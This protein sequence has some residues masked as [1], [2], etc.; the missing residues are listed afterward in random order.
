MTAQHSPAHVVRRPRS[1]SEWFRTHCRPLPLVLGAAVLGGPM[2]PHVALAA[3][4]RFVGKDANP[5]PTE[6]DKEAVDQPP[7]KLNY[8]IPKTWE[9]ILK[10]V[11]EQTNST[12][13]ADKVP[14]GT[15]SRRDR[16]EYTREEAVRIINQEIEKLGFRVVEKGEYLVVIDL[17]SQRPRYDRPT[18]P[19]PGVWQ[20][21]APYV[22]IS[23]G[24]PPVRQ[25][26]SVRPQPQ[27][28]PQNQQQV[29]NSSQ[30]APG[31]AGSSQRPARTPSM[32]QQT[33]LE[34]ADYGEPQP[35]P[36]GRSTAQDLLLDQQAAPGANAPTTVVVFRARN[37]RA[38]SLAKHV[39]K[40]FR[41]R[42]ELLQAGRNGLPAF[43]VRSEVARSAESPV[44]FAVAI[45]EEKEELLIDAPA[46]DADAM[47]KLLRKL[48][49]PTLEAEPIQ[50]V[51]TTRTVCEVAMQFESQ[52]EKIQAARRGRPARV[53]D[54]FAQ[55]DFSESAFAQADAP[56]DP[57]AP[58]T[59]MPN[60]AGGET[61]VVPRGA[62]GDVVGNLKG[63]VVIESVPDL[64]T[65]ILKGNREDV[66][67]V[68]QVIRELEKLSEQTA[69][70]LELL[71]LQN[72]NSDALAEL[73]T[74][75]YESLTKFP[76]R[77]TQ[78]RQSVA[79]LSVSKPNAILIIAPA[80]DMP[81]IK[82]LASELDRPVDPET[83]FQVFHLETAIATQVE[84]ML[85]QFFTERPGLG[86]RV[87]VR[88]DP[89]SN[90]IIVSARPNDLDE[91][92]T[93]IRKLDQHD[94]MS[95]SQL[96][97]VPLQ[98]AVATELSAV[99]NLAI[100]S[101]ISP[102]SSQGATSIFGAGAGVG[103]AQVSEE[104]R[105]VRSSVLQFLAV[106]EAGQKVLRSGVLADI[107]ITPDPRMNSL[108]ISAP[109]ASMNLLVELIKQLDRPTNQVAEIKV[110]TL[111]NADAQL[112][113]QQ[114]QALFSTSAAGQGGQQQRQLGVQVAGAEDASSGLI[115]LR[116][117]V[118]TRTNS[119]IAI[120]GGDALRVVEA[121]MLRLDE[122]DVRERRNTIYRLKNS[123]SDSIAAAITSFFTSQSDLASADPN[124]FSSIEQLERNVIVVSEPVSN[125]LMISAT[126]RYN[127][128]ILRLI[129]KLD[130]APQQVIIQALLVEV[131]LNDT[132]EFGIELG[133][134]D[135]ILFDRSIIDN[136][137][138]TTTTT[139][140]NNTTVTQ[141]NVI[142][143]SSSP[144]YLFGNPATPL[145]NNT[146]PSVPTGRVGTQGLSN[147]SVG[148]TNGDLGFG[149]LV[150]SASSESVSLLLRALSENRQV[151]VLSRPQIRTLDNQ[152]AQ[153]VQGQNVPI[154]T[155]VTISSNGGVP[156]PQVT[157]D[158]AGV[159]LNVTPRIS[160]DGNV[161]MALVAE[162]S[163][164]NLQSGVAIFTDAAT[165]NTVTSPVK[166]LSTATTTVS[167]PSGQT[168]V[169]GGLITSRTDEVHR[170][171]PWLGDIPVLGYA[172]RYDFLQ[173]RRTELLIFLTPRI[174]WDDAESEH[175]KDV[176]MARIHFIE[177]AAE[178][179]HGP[180]RGV[181]QED[182]Y[183]G[184]I[185]PN[186]P[187]IIDGLPPGAVI[188]SITPLNTDPSMPPSPA[189]GP[190]SPMNSQPVP[191]MPPSGEL[192]QPPV[193]QF[194]ASPASPPAA[195]PAAPAPASAAPAAAGKSS[196]PQPIAV[197]EAG[198]PVAPPPP[199]EIEGA[200][201]MPSKA[202]GS[203]T[204]A[205]SLPV[206]DGDVQPAGG[207]T[208]GSR[209][210][211]SVIQQM[212]AEFEEPPRSGSSRNPAAAATRP[213]AARTGSQNAA[214][215]APATAR[216]QPAKTTDKP[217]KT[218]AKP[219]ATEKE[220]AEKAG[221]VKL[222]RKLW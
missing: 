53:A 147:F 126:P 192:P 68:M 50:L 139:T 107:R 11:A 42:S 184:V 128:E 166:D 13:V 188:K 23:Q 44:Q 217:A 179:M 10:D 150:L 84:A 72:V 82:T 40:A 58:V 38:A 56:V 153:I 106:D 125:S 15:F 185:D 76:G 130:A 144:G 191:M 161:V 57:A 34:Q 91:V 46:A 74:Q 103:G 64:G 135:S 60:A 172:F 28:Q 65:L 48:D 216:V 178:E 136:L 156:S 47:L 122:S 27:A 9:Q 198:R 62:L 201:W 111:A 16:N 145:G 206:I 17:P 138:T 133:F 132:D 14:K 182:A 26:D 131:E 85:T 92:A 204:P 99:L 174:I 173:T 124:L 86:A 119:V 176:E 36:A 129:E 69:P 55:A 207:M 73:L 25:F 94:K 123:P 2:L 121:I 61:M 79:I 208:T 203:A 194:P 211:G 93:L 21:P 168:I 193:P 7:V 18:V 12:L 59:P 31:T 134:Q 170:K 83:E 4:P 96:K 187:M 181:P 101:V 104:F 215:S 77:A 52:S 5:K 219:Q 117:S 20:P 24:G 70:Q 81:G 197:D 164:Y 221:S 167:V 158:D 127:D 152:Q 120:G 66:E 116:F 218:A 148:R 200:G 214:S 151:R 110:F 162:K 97:V 6:A 3:P 45:D 183:P 143:Q 154:V 209:S 190:Q 39:F 115:P 108:L 163:Q 140:E 212:S 80:A 220:T 165:G 118:D 1:L 37:Q 142:S 169:L 41:D 67:Q 63:E 32:I 78:P 137:V 54:P 222:G 100:Q 87:L 35:L 112:M 29:A 71:L 141:T 90:S 157:R 8:I 175:I 205:R 105:T 180:L 210:T 202:K 43:R 30:A 102:P 213:T 75:V 159:I 196:I 189:W 155:G 88:A 33:S 195:A 146:S 171:V 177:G 19:Q 49:T 160:P 95:A 199:P 114:L 22:P 89:R 186:M 51:S 98:N 149:G 109:E 113:V